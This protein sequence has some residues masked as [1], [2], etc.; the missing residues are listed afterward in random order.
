[1]QLVRVSFWSLERGVQQSSLVL[2]HLTASS[3]NGQ[4]VHTFLSL[5]VKNTCKVAHIGDRSIR[6]DR[7]QAI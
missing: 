7:L 6:V 1:M 5:R 2:A 3:V 4:G